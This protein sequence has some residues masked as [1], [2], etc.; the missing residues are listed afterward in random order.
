MANRKR[1]YRPTNPIDIQNYCCCSCQNFEEVEEEDPNEISQED[2]ENPDHEF[3]YYLY[4]NAPQEFSCGYNYDGGGSSLTWFR[5]IKVC[6]EAK[7]VKN[8]FLTGKP[9]FKC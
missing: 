4:E 1:S 8:Q 5:E 7:M 6:I 9:T 3:C 2:L